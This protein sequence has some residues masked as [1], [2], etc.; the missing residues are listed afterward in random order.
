LI[1]AELNPF[2]NYAAM[3][4]LRGEW[5]EDSWDKFEL[6]PNQSCL[7]DAAE[8][9]IRYPVN[10]VRWRIENSHRIDLLP[11]PARLGVP[12]GP[13]RHGYRVNGKVLPVDERFVEHWSHNP[14]SLDYGGD[15]RN[16]ADG[17]AYLLG[18]YMGLYHKFIVEN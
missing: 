14:W 7:D 4:S 6:T 10:L 11:I 17:A 1:A 18:Y 12:K 9:L 3:A 13:F 2:Y 16:V 5:Y 8:T 15:G